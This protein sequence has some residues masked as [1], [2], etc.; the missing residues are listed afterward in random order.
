MLKLVL[1]ANYTSVSPKTRAADLYARLRADI[2][3][4]RL[5]PGARLRFNETRERYTTGLTPLR[6]ALMRLAQ[7]GLVVLEDQRGFHVAPVSAKDLMDVARMRAELESMAL[8]LSIKHGNDKWEVAVVGSLHSLSKLTKFDSDLLISKEWECRHDAFHGA[9]ASAC[10][11][12]W[13]LRMRRIL[14]ERADRYRRLAVKYGEI[15]RD[16]GNEHRRLAEA[17]L[18]R[19]VAEA[20]SLMR[21]HIETTAQVLLK[22]VDVEN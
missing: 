13:L 15:T 7:E 5:R 11:S 20:T 10:D 17:A 1:N 21:E 18:R 2:L 6:E 3:E 22:S 19:D 9:L 14:Y 8:K 16:E 12:E 4:C